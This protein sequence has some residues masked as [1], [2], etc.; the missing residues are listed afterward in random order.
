MKKS[1][2]V[3]SAMGL[4]IAMPAYVPLA[5]NPLNKALIYALENR[6]NAKIKCRSLNV[7]LWRSVTASGIEALGSGGFAIKADRAVIDYDFLSLVT[8][9]LHVKCKL[10]EA[11]FYKKSS[12]AS[13]V[14]DLLHIEPI[15]NTTFNTVQ[16]NFY[17][18][19]LDTLTQ[20]LALIGNDIK[21]YINAVTDKNDNI[22]GL[23]RF[24]ISDK[25]ATDIPDEIRGTALQKEKGPWSSIDIGIMGN[26]Q[27]PSIRIMTE[28]FRMNILS[29]G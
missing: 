5:L 4:L 27:T 29:R 13:S 24:F 28:R 7:R 3:L 6:L 14:T 18:G 12:I 2:I 17:V 22:K 10:E 26:Y 15:G 25:I 1:I 11:K 20:D 9:R 8:G 23:I 16:G 21:I 19:R